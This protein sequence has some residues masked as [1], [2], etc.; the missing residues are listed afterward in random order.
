VTAPLFPE[1][2]RDPRPPRRPSLL[3]RWIS[4]WARL[5]RPSRPWSGDNIVNAFVLTLLLQG[6]WPGVPELDG[7]HDLVVLVWLVWIA[8]NVIGSW[9]GRPD[10]W[11]W[12]R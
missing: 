8:G 10:G 3:E 7:L 9:L 2:W 5:R 11:P 12:R 6:A 4:W 1:H